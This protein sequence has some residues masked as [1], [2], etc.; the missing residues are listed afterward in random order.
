MRLMFEK[1][2]FGREIVNIIACEGF[3][4]VERPQT[5]KQWQLR[6]MRNGFRLLPLDHR[7]IGKLKD[8]LRD[9]AHNNN[10]L[11]EV[12]GDWVLQGWKGRILYASSCWVPA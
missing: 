9:D 12:D 10:F 4:R 1:E 7:I 6:N 11:L 3:E 8:R 5:Y 2:L